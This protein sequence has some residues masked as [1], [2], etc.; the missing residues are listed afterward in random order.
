MTAFHH[1][2]SLFIAA[3]VM[4]TLGA[5]LTTSPTKDITGLCHMIK[6]LTICVFRDGCFKALTQSLIAA[7]ISAIPS[8]KTFALAHESACRSGPR[9]KATSAGIRPLNWPPL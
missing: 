2:I 5:S 9:G 7:G 3:I 1:L 8:Y 4:D 6:V